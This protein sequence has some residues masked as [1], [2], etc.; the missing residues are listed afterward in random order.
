MIQSISGH[1]RA[2]RLAVE[3]RWHAPIK[4]THA[5]FGWMVMHASWLQNHYQ[6]LKHGSTAFQAV[7]QRAYDGCIFQFA[8]A[9]MVR[10]QYAAEGVPKLEERWW[11]GLW[12]GKTVEADDHLVGT[13][14]G[15]VRSR[16]VR[17][18]GASEQKQE[19]F[20]KMTWTPWQPTLQR[21]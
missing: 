1:V 2:L 19:L 6:I 9:V 14:Y 7:Q 12:L 11:P 4:A 16:S 13:A 5:L 20:D 8:E 15:I 3:E 18:L 17:P 21:T 10:R